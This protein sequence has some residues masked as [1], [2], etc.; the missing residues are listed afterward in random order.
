MSSIIEIIN[1]NYIYYYLGI[2]NLLT[3]YNIDDNIFKLI[4]NYLLYSIDN[5][6]LLELKEMIYMSN[7]KHE[8]YYLQTNREFL[9]SYIKNNKIQIKDKSIMDKNEIEYEYTIENF[10]RGILTSGINIIKIN[11]KRT[12]AYYYEF[13]SEDKTRLY[14]LILLNIR[15]R[16]I[17]LRKDKKCYIVYNITNTTIVL[18]LYNSILITKKSIVFSNF[19]YNEVMDIKEFIKLIDNEFLSIIHL[20]YESNKRRNIYYTNDE[21]KINVTE[22]IDLY[23]NDTIIEKN[24]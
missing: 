3:N 12:Y 17:F 16:D 11:S 8:Y 7:L 4:Y 1:I 5:Y 2:T 18:E 10:T 14:N 13:N 21:S 24:D 6:N 22:L 23:E 19:L 15:N 9:L 20:H